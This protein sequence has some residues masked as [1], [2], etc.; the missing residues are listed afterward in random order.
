MNLDVQLGPVA[1]TSPLIAA[2]G[3]VGSVVDFNESI[4]FGFYGAAVA[5]SVSPEPWHGKP[6]PRIAPTAAGMLNG[7]GIQNPG[8][9]PWV[10]EFGPR[11][12]SV[13]TPVWGSVVAHNVAGF[14][15]VARVMTE[16]G[17]TA[18]E[19]N[20]SC[21]NLDG[22]PFALDPA[23]SANV[24]EEVRE[25]TDLPIGA[26][27][28]PDAQ[29]ISAVA[30]AVAAAGADWVVISNTVMG[31][32]IDTQTR[33]PLLSGAIGGYSGTAIR[34][35]TVRKILEVARDVPGIPIVGCGGVS[36]AEHVVELM[37]AGATAVGIG[38]AHFATPRIA[39]SMT[40]DLHRYGGKRKVTSIS[41][42]TGAAEAW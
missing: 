18:I 19:I 9:D 27:L 5:K 35:I 10:A 4:D 13:P 24:V 14:A 37:L 21:P 2:A 29:P 41:T 32:A 17:V 16:A 25:A 39:V 26:K 33:R 8:V 7:I 1:L 20:L 11:L 28:S 6:A 38:T 12:A 3:T 30:E 42:L 40:K 36:T 31:A 23:L 15:H 34:P 22:A